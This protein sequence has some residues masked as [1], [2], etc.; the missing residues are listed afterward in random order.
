MRKREGEIMREW[1]LLPSALLLLQVSDEFLLF[2]FPDVP[3]SASFSVFLPRGLPSISVWI[4]GIVGE[5]EG[6]EK[7]KN[8][9]KRV[10][11]FEDGLSVFKSHME[12]NRE[13]GERE[14]DREKRSF[15]SDQR[16]CF[17]QGNCTVLLL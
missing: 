17:M 14:K 15:W 1:L 16:G 13:S 5:G 12:E 9:H 8:T 2:G 10:Y 11:L 3:S 6:K 7:N 4:E